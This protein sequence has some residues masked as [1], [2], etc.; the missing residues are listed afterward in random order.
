MRILWGIPVPFAV[1]R[2]E[3]RTR[4]SGADERLRLTVDNAP[5]GMTMVDLEHRFVDPNP[6]LC[7]MLGYPAEE[8]AGMTF[9]QVSHEDELDLDLTH[10]QRLV[11]G[12]ID[13]YEIEKR[14]LRRDGSV[15]WGRLAASLVRDEDGE[16]RYFVSQIQDISEF[17]AAQDELEQ[18]ALYDSLTGVGNRNLLMDRL[19]AALLASPEQPRTP[20]AVAFCD[21]DDFK[22]INDTYGHAIGDLV[23]KEVAHRLRDTV[24]GNDTVARMGSDEFVILFPQVESP[25]EAMTVFDRAQRVVAQPM[26]IDG[27]TLSVLMSGGVA[28]GHPGDRPDSLLRNADVAMYAAKERGGGRAVTYHAALRGERGARVPVGLY[29]GMQSVIRDALEH[30]RVELAYQPVFDLS[31]GLMVSSEA[32]LRLT[33]AHGRQ[34]PP[35]DVIPAAEASG[36]IIDVGRRVLQLAAAQ[37]ARWRDQHG[38][39]LP[40]AVNVSAVQLAQPSFPDELFEFI[41]QAGAQPG[42]LSLELTESVLVEAGFGGMERL[43]GLSSAGVELAIDDFGTGYAS[44]SYLH[45]LPATTVKIDQSFVA[46]IP[47]DERAVAIVNGVIALADNFGMSCIAEG[48]ETEAQRAYL[49][50]RGV[51]GQGH[52][53]GRPGRADAIDS[54]IDSGSAAPHLDGPV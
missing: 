37:S 38:V 35:R 41:R 43:L 21:L 4:R 17:R 34:V 52:L 49:A 19:T 23:L 10:V 48:I 27:H 51:L 30:D 40:I 44:L 2:A 12:D 3:D 47:E 14:Y 15:L 11:A 6:R 13:S 54:I 28:L 25:Q 32:L 50:A 9:E 29:D 16:P 22:Q 5:I 18:R 8:L 45:D 33:D 24:R 26:V 46:G 39:V 7:S 53:L 31:T 20:V 42:S 1:R 36:L